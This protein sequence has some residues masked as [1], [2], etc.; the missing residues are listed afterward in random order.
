MSLFKTIHAKWR[1]II[2]KNRIFSL[3]ESIFK[4]YGQVL[5]CLNSL[6][7]LT[8]SLLVFF[9]SKRLWLFTL[10]GVGCAVLIA[11]LLRART[12]H[13][14]SGVYGFNSVI[15]GLAW[16]WFVKINTVSIILFLVIACLSSLIIKFLID[17]TSRI[18]SNPPFL[19]VPAVILIWAISILFHLFP[20]LNNL[21]GPDPGILNSLENFQT[22]LT[23]LSRHFDLFLVLKTFRLHI[24]CLMV[25]LLAVGLH[26]RISLLLAT[27]YFLMTVFVV[28]FL[29]GWQ[30][31]QY[32]ELYV[33][34]SIPC[35]VALG[36]IFLVLTR[37]VF[38]LSCLAVILVNVL[39]FLGIRYFP[40]PVF[41]LP[42]NFVT[43]L[44]I[45]MVKSGW[46]KRE[47]D[48]YGVP[49]EM[50]SSPEL[51]L[52]WLKGEIYAQ[53]YWRKMEKLGFKIFYKNF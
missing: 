36:G 15:L 52:Q 30:E 47:H 23:H 22:N 44:A 50:V 9:V 37:P 29:G 40:L 53:N 3:L 8:L 35:G 14:H 45:V 31:F 2:S 4:S 1:E 26:S 46:L 27:F 6:T 28:F 51:G 32:I 34:N 38:W 25:I 20:F 21:I 16:P 10:M 13:I 7:G 48:F 33:Y 17:F 24:F 41:V 11:L 12:F 42:F 5:I 43:I 18:K 49:M 39:V 19:S